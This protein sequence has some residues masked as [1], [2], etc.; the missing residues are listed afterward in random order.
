M[1]KNNR[2]QSGK[3][4]TSKPSI[5][6]GKRVSVAAAAVAVLVGAFAV[7][8]QSESAQDNPQAAPSASLVV[9]PSGAAAAHLAS[10]APLPTPSGARQQSLPALAL[11]PARASAAVADSKARL[12]D[13]EKME[14]AADFVPASADGATDNPPFAHISLREFSSGQRAIDLLGRD[15][16]PV[17][18]WYGM[19]ADSLSHLLL[20]DSSVHL[21]RKGRIVH[22]DEGIA[23]GATAAGAPT[24]ATGVTTVASPFPLDQT[25]LL[26][27]KADS[28][29]VLFL[30]FKG[31]GANP[32][33][34][35][36][37]SPATYSDAER[38]M[39]QNIWLRV[40]EDYAAFD[41]DITTEAPAI[42]AGKIG[43]T[44]LITPQSSTAGG[45][46]YLN[47][48]AK[49]AAGAAPAFC[50]PNNLANSEKPIAECISHEAG[51]TLGLQHQGN[52]ASAYYGGQGDGIT[53]WAPIMG[54]SYYKNLS[55]WAKGEY[56]G[57]NNKEDAYAVMLRQ[58]LHP[59]ADDHGNT[60]ATAS[61]LLSKS[62]N[63]LANL[64]ASGVIETPT[65][66]DMF[67]FVAGSGPLS[68]KVAAAAIGADLDVSLELLDASGKVLA[69]ANPLAELNAGISVNIALPG[70]YYLSVKGTGNGDPLKTGYSNYGSIGQYSI[71]GTAALVVI[72]PP[73]LTVK[74]SASRGSGSLA[75]AFSGAATA[76][77][78]AT[79]TSYQWNFGDGSASVAGL[80]ASHTYTKAGTYEAVLKVSDSRG[81]TS[82]KGVA[83][84]LA[85]AAPVRK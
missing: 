46:A 66:V 41:V 38:L 4:S 65:D 71:S 22:I 63:G 61:A 9:P 15:L 28:S 62:A 44:V 74:A 8:G 1:K 53:G 37:K 36:D 35:L 18:N 83:I 23:A 20:T 6:T 76:A 49:F 3:P 33:F 2:Q 60:I 47:S 12:A 84:T 13:Y 52:A 85:A 7:A 24:V 78:G 51:H 34:S 39:I 56:S 67:S 27:S 48:F 43:A 55:Q 68:L 17:A 50:F 40:V 10:P 30:N 32:S 70:T 58:G 54:V 73:T 25:F 31:Q 82:S 77:S 16:A 11:V 19:T 72:T 81:Q 57:A 26:H 14:M 45:Y 80:N 69:S 42:P 5:W 29:R 64:S 75:V 21:D 79:I 59:R